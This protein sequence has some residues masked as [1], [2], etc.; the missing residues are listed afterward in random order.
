[1]CHNV[2]LI[3]MLKLEY[4]ARVK[5][6]GCVVFGSGFELKGTKEGIIIML[7]NQAPRKVE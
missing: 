6:V 7:D 5:T 1:M 2:C 4:L 3:W